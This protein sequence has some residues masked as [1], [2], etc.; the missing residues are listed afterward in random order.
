VTDRF[1]ARRAIDGERRNGEGR[2]EAR[3]GGRHA[4]PR[5]G[6]ET[7]E[8]LLGE[9][10]LS[11]FGTVTIDYNR[12]ILT[13]TNPGSAGYGALIRPASAGYGAIAWDQATGRSGWS[14]NQP[15][16]ATAKELAL[17]QCGTSGCKV[18]MESGPSQCAALATTDDR[19]H[20]GAAWR[21]TQEDARMAALANCLK[22]NAGECVLRFSECNK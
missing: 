9:S 17:S 11:K 8:P 4:R 21:M 22:S 1:G 16:A 14:W 6:Q 10:F 20:V 2:F 7:G 15:T 18:V 5:G 13:L 12:L 19:K 3:P